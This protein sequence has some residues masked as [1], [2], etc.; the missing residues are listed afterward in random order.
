MP[1]PYF[2]HIPPTNQEFP[3]T[4]TSCITIPS[5]NSCFPIHTTQNNIPFPPPHHISIMTLSLIVEH[6]D[7]ISNHTSMHHST[8]VPQLTLVSLRLTGPAQ[9]REVLSLKRSPSRLGENSSRGAA[10]SARSRSG[11][12]LLA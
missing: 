9:A 11:K 8:I 4:L 1:Y 2:I 5:Y 3:I 7:Q 6:I 10:D 12:S